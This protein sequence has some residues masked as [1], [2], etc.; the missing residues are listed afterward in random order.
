MNTNPNIRLAASLLALAMTLIA[1]STQNAFAANGYA[2]AVLADGPI[3]YYRFGDTRDTNG[4]PTAANSGSLGAAANGIYNGDATPG[5]LAPRPPAFPGFEASNTALQ[6][7]GAGDFVGTIAGLMN[8]RPIFTISG[9]M[10]RNGDQADRTGLWGQNDLVEFGYI[11]NNTL[12]LWTDNGLDVSPNPIPNGEWAHIAVVSDGSP[13][14]ASMYTNG[15]LALSR[16]HSLPADNNFAFNIGGGGVF[17]AT[18]NFFAG[19]IDEVAVFAKALTPEQIAA[20][21]AAAFIAIKTNVFT[22]GDPI[23]LVN[24]QNDGDGDA[25]PPPSAETVDHVIDRVGQKYLNFLDLGSGFAATPSIGPTVVKCIRFYTANDAEGRDPASFTLEGTLLGLAGPWTA[26]AS[27]PL[28]LPS[29]R[30]PGGAIPINPATQFNQLVTFENG[31]P[32]TSYR[33]TFPTLKDAAGA[34][35]MQIGEVEL[36]GNAVPAS[37]PAPTVVFTSPGPNAEA[38]QDA[39]LCAE[40]TLPPLSTC[41]VTQVC[42]L[43]NGSPLG[44]ATAA[45]WCITVPAAAVRPAT[46]ILTAVAIDTTG[47]QTPSAPLSVKVADNQPPTVNCPSDITVTS[48]TATAVTYVASA[49][50]ACVLRSFDCSPP[51]GSSFPLGLT[52]V[53]C[54]AVDTAGNSNSCSFKVTVK[55]PNSPPVC[56]VSLASESCGLHFANDPNTYAIALDDTACVAL[57]GAG[58][59]DPDNDP[60]QFFWLVDGQFTANLDPAQEPGG[61]GGTGSG[62]GTFTLSGNTI[63]VDVTFSGLSA[64]S[65]ASH[66]HGPAP[67]GINAGVLYPLNQFATLG[68]TAGTIQG[69]VTLV[70]G[71]GGFTLAQQLEQ[72]HAGLWYVNVHTTTHQGGEIRGQLDPGVLSGPVATTCLGLGCHSVMLTVSDGQAQ[73]QCSLDLCVITGCEAVEQCI[74]LVDDSVIARKNK[75]P[76]I[77]SLKAACASLDRGSL[78][79]ALGQLH[80]FQ[81]KVR[82]QVA[83]SNPDEARAFIQCAQQIVTAIDCAAD[84]ANNPVGP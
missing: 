74:K 41:V 72:L 8:S 71:T 21:Y 1:T 31:L 39:T 5:A 20:Q 6:L 9:W 14:T 60:L 32:Y 17:D 18:G 4:P 3:A 59:S 63:T 23:V 2:D 38:C 78:E 36:L 7:D 53:T 47:K 66:I 43:A 50:D 10:R 76:L 73:S 24:G 42:F 27:G 61:S 11:N 67:R 16:A 13:G 75:R 80:A 79:S 54:T 40:V 44:C 33:V 62:T 28:S 70:E 34:N 19:Q 68:G 37:C 12:E 25:G 64:N 77:A 56:V 15:V 52:T 49:T 45:P 29:G 81:N 35:S 69:T 83:P 46:Y 65:T 30:N 57:S 51:S 26:I 84:A 82:A 22:P 58:S 55:S 48:A